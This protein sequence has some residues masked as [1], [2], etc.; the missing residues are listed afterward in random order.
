MVRFVFRSLALFAFAFACT[1]AVI[2]A[3]RSVGASAL[4]LT[5]FADTLATLSPDLLEQWGTWLGNNVHVL[6]RDPVLATV[7]AWPTWSVTG[8]LAVLLYAIGHRPKGRRGRF[9]VS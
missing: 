9:I 8:G 2:D 6:L 1:F 7:A 3:A 4:V 5:P